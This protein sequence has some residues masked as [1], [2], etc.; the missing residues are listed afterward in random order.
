MCGAGRKSLARE[1]KGRKLVVDGRGMRT[2]KLSL[3]RLPDADP[4]MAMLL[5]VAPGVEVHVSA[6][7]VQRRL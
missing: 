4:F 6:L 7:S 2:R 5:T 1:N 3:R